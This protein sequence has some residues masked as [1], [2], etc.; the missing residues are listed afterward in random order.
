MTREYDRVRRLW[1]DWGSSGRVLF[2]D[3]PTVPAFAWRAWDSQRNSAIESICPVLL[4]Q[5]HALRVPTWLGIAYSGFSAGSHSKFMHL[6]SNHSVLSAQ[7]V[8]ILSTLRWVI[9]AKQHS[10]R[11]PLNEDFTASHYWSPS[12]VFT[13]SR[14]IGWGNRSILQF[15]SGADSC[16]P[17][18]LTQRGTFTWN[19]TEV[20]YKASSS[21]VSISRTALLGAVLQTIRRRSSS[22]QQEEAITDMKFWEDIMAHLPS[23]AL[24]YVV[25]LARTIK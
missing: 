5:L 12:A 24:I 15:R 3:E 9:V 4:Q 11:I 8:F 22:F 6:L 10:R 18:Y 17:L 13:A 16:T 25:R 21:I 2:Q 19:T 23:N 7:N 1:E 14:F 20:R